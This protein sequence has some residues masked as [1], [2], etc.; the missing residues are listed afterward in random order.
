MRPVW[1]IARLEIKECLRS[2]IIYVICALTL[3]F[4][5]LGR[6]CN[7]GNSTVNASLFSEEARQNISVSFAFHMISF[8]SMVLC[9]LIASGILPKEFED[10]KLLMILCR[11]VKRS[12]FLTGKLLAV[13]L[14]SSSSFFLFSSIFFTLFYIDAGQVNLKIIPGAFL[15]LINLL[16]I[17]VISFFSSLFLPRML[18]PLTGLLIYI[19]SIGIEIPFYFDKIRMVWTPS[20]ALQTIHQLFPRLGAVQFLCGSFVNTMPS[21]DAC[22]TP[23]SNVILY[24]FVLWLAV[25]FIFEKRQL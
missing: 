10:K 25:V 18:A 20:A 5:L 7:A 24:S 1:A 9:G 3:L 22:L 21:L 11:P 2:K 6:G 8:W 23:M 16:S 15:L 17:A 13:M 14:I 12:S 19:M 4:I